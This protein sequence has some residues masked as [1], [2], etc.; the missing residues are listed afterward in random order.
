MPRPI[1]P[2]VIFAFW[3]V[4]GAFSISVLQFSQAQATGG[5]GGLIKVG[6]D[7]PLAEAI[8]SEV[9]GIPVAPGLGHDG[10]L[11]YAIGLDLTGNEIPAMMEPVESAAYRY[12]RIGYPALSSL[13]GLLDGSRLIWGMAVVNAASVGLAAAATAAIAQHFRRTP[14]AALAVVLNPGVWL[15][16][17]LLTADNLAL[18]VG[19][20]AVLAFLKRQVGWATAALAVAVLTKEAALAFSLGLAGFAWWSTRDRKTAGWLIAGSVLP[21]AAWLT[22]VHAGIGNLLASG[23]ALGLPFDGLVTAA[24]VWGD[25]SLQNNLFNGL[26]LAFMAVGAFG[27]FDRRLLWRWLIW[28]WIVIALVSSRFVWIFGNNS[29]R[30]FAPMIVLT[31]LALTDERFPQAAPV[32]TAATP[33][34]DSSLIG[35][36]TA[37]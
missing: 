4:V 24:G 17:L 2:G 27:L 8:T 37:P 18:A 25:Q 22:I 29:V 30:V 21:L 32:H 34:D 35:R 19:L 13:F 6:A 15:S 9:P 3:F 26:T 16:A 10:Q 14:W 5:I 7:H 36:T 20:L 31:V 11:Y 23:A 12:R 33:A 1:S 28:P